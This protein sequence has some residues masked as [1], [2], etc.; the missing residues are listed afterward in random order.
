MPDVN[1][2]VP[3][4]KSPVPDEKE[5]AKNYETLRVVSE[6][7]KNGFTVLAIII[8]GWW[9]YTHFLRAEAPSL[10][11]RAFATSVLDWKPVDN[12]RCEA[13]FDV[14]FTN[15]GNSSVRIVKLWVRGW[16]YDRDSKRVQ[17]STSNQPAN[18]DVAV[19]YLDI[20]KIKESKPIFDKTFSNNPTGGVYMFIGNY[21]PTASFRHS[22][23]FSVTTAPTRGVYFEANFFKETSSGPEQVFAYTGTWDEVCNFS[24]PAPTPPVAV[25][26]PTPPTN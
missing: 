20:E 7:V 24:K 14:T 23:V 6:I 19:T 13:F 8:G 10:E 5:P 26:S 25:S 9:T 18:A 16:Q 12:Q 11:P 22:F 2:P 3:D 15:S 1:T 17:G 4:A 21:P